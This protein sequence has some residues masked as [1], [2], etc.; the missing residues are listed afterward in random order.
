LCKVFRAVIVFTKQQL[1]CPTVLT[2]SGLLLPQQGPAIQFEY[3]PQSQETSSGIQYWPCFGRLACCPT[4][5]LSLCALPHLCSVLVR[6]LW[7]VVLSLHPHSQPLFLFLPSFTESLAPWS[8]P[9][10]WGRLS[11]PPH[12]CCW[13]AVYTLVLLERGIQS[14]Q[15]LCWIM[16]LGGGCG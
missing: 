12:P 14:A 5:A 16:F 9:I 4:P 3:C 1:H 15:W 7:E 6:L 13:F 11:V 10:L 8:I 2:L